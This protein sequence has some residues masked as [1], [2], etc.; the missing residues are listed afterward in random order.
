M[1]S[2]RKKMSGVILALTVTNYMARYKLKKDTQDFSKR[3]HKERRPNNSFDVDG[4]VILPQKRNHI[5]VIMARYKLKKDTQDFSKRQFY[6]GQVFTILSE[7]GKKG[8]PAF[9]YEML[10]T[11]TKQRIIVS[12][13]QLSGKFEK[14]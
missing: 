2:A 12:E 13:N 4:E 3:Q 10:C 8:T 14:L 11:S 5:I 7:Q 6:K 1:Q 9:R